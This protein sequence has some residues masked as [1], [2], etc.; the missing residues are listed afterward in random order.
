MTKRS[1]LINPFAMFYDL[2][3]MHSTCLR[4]KGRSIITV[5]NIFTLSVVLF[6]G[7]GVCLSA[8]WDTT[9]P[10]ADRP[11]RADT[12]QTRHTPG[13]R[14]LLGPDTPRT[15][16]PWTRHPP[17]SRHPPGNRHSPKQTPPRP[18]TPDQTPPDQT[19]LPGPDT[20][21][22]PDTPQT[23]Y[24]RDQTPPQTRH[25]PPQF[26]FFGFFFWIFLGGDFFGFFFA[27]PC[28]PGSRLWHTVNGRPVCI[29]LEC[30]LVVQFVV[31]Q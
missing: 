30:I 18:D 22:G 8:C 21:L 17:G 5:G 12:P 14:H 4:L 1:I 2:C 23:R 3:V 15:R 28:P 7:G 27:S 10:G 24:P 20:P 31:F 26:I 13:T 29:L 11:P 25:P 19:A 16:H 9:P 6:T